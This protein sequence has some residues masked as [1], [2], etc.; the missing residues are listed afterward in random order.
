MG[1]NGVAADKGDEI[2]H[3]HCHGNLQQLRVALNVSLLFGV[4][5]DVWF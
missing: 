3:A 1:L 4:S 2:I 5:T